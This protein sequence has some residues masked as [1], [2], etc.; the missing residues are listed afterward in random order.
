[1]KICDDN[2]ASFDIVNPSDIVNAVDQNSLWNSTLDSFEQPLVTEQV[3]QQQQHFT[4]T[5]DK[6]GTTRED[7]TCDQ[8]F[9]ASFNTANFD[10]CFDEYGPTTVPDTL[11]GDLSSV[12]DQVAW[13]I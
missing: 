5:S 13:G 1:M 9:E 3:F 4:E 10:Y 6:I 2:Y 12:I 7:I 11:Y 8:S